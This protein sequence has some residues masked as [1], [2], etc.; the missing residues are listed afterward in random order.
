MGGTSVAGS[1]IQT[2]T[3]VDV[4]RGWTECP[5][6]IVHDGALAVEAIKR[7]QSLFPWLLR[8]ADCDNDSS[9]MNDVVVPWCWAQKIEVTRSR[10]F[11]KN[12]QA[13]VEQKNGAVVRRLVEPPPI[14]ASGTRTR[15]SLD[16][17]R[18]KQ[19]GPI[20]KPADLED[21]DGGAASWIRLHSWSAAW[22][23]QSGER[24]SLIST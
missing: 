13:L 10:A 18:K 6:L 16:I 11:K 4:A 8:G 19:P 3:M 21:Q 12:D 20:V 22:L 5:P 14:W 23:R 2:L 15:L 9:F 24:N 1:F 7:A 17:A